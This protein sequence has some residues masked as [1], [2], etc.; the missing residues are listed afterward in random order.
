MTSEEITMR[1]IVASLFTTVDGVVEAPERWHFPY[2]NEEMGAL[3]GSLMRD[4]QLL[5][6]RTY[7]T[8]AATWAAREV[9]GGDDAA[10]AAQIGNQRKIVVSRQRLE[11]T[12]R[13]SEQLRGDLVDGVTSLKADTGGDIAISGS[14][15][16]V[17]QLLDAKLI[18]ELHLLV[19]PI[20]VG[21]GA[22]LFDEQHGTSL[23]L[24]LLDSTALSNGVVHLVYGPVES[25]PG[26]TYRAASKAM[27]DALAAGE[28]ADK[29]IEPA[30]DLR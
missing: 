29:T 23:P 25:A 8:F 17:R 14:V 28:R 10:L 21:K 24:R 18:D 11:F 19:D 5:G 16:V 3:V 6:R 2:F 30:E 12:W 4:T 13:N 9:A 1:R 22:R 20:A 15:S 26:G 27:V 7:E